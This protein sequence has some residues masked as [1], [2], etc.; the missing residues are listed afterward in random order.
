M[1]NLIE[2]NIVSSS[3]FMLILSY[4]DDKNAYMK[5]KNASQLMFGFSKT[6]YLQPSVFELLKG[7][8]SASQV[9][10]PFSYRD[11]KNAIKNQT[12]LFAQ[13][14]YIALP[15]Y[16]QVL[17]SSDLII[18]D[19]QEHSL[20]LYQTHGAKQNYDDILAKLAQVFLQEYNSRVTSS[21]RL[22]N[23]PIEKL[24]YPQTEQA[25]LSPFIVIYILSQL[26]IGNKKLINTTQK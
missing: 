5:K 11:F 19:L 15:V 16:N 7:Q 14:D 20:T 25:N 18:I 4:L 24:F 12:N 2:L 21:G 13:F 9:F 22:D 3:T 1:K 8:V 6:L 23:W 26:Q 17:Y 10:P